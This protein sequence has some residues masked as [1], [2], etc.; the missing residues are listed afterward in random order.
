MTGVWKINIFRLLLSTKAWVQLIVL[1][2]AKARRF[3]SFIRSFSVRA[4]LGSMLLFLIG[5]G[6]SVC[7][8]R[9]CA[10]SVELFYMFAFQDTTLF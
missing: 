4:P 10:K 6:S 8:L 7:S 5:L 3:Q 1:Q 2:V 9:V